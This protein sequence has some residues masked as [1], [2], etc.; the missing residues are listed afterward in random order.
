MWPDRA[1][2]IR[3]RI[4]VLFGAGNRPDSPT[5]KECG[6]DELWDNPIELVTI[7]NATKEA[8]GRIRAAPLALALLAVERQGIHSDGVT[9]KRSMKVGTQLVRLV[10]QTLGNF[11][12][13]QAPSDHCHTFLCRE[14]VRLN[15]TKC[16]RTLS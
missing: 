15:F 13:F 12:L 14:G 9:P 11:R 1:I 6:L 5:R 16:N 4:K 7:S 2:A 3:H 10:R 8:L